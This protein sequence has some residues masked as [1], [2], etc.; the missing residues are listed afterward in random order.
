M[1]YLSST[2]VYAGAAATGE[3][4]ALTVRPQR[5]DHLYNLSKLT[6]EALCL[7]RPEPTVRVARLSNVIGAGD[8]PIN[9]LPSV[10][11]ECRRKGGVVLRTSAKSS[12]DYIAVDEVCGLLP[13][14]ATEGRQR[15][16][17]VASGVN[18]T[19]AVIAQLLRQRMGA[20]VK[21]SAGA[22]T[23]TFPQID[24]ARIRDEFGFAAAPFETSLAALITGPQP[25]IGAK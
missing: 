23:V 4:A 10:L 9:F 5:P 17:N 7:A 8:S 12:K 15:I 11:A 2:R 18:T 14:I 16:Y 19:N 24:I 25:S 3:E 20:E 6:G 13:R 22:E 21:F 1:L